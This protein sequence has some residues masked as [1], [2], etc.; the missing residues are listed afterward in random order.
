M[1]SLEYHNCTLSIRV[2]ALYTTF[3]TILL[4]QKVY[5]EKYIILKSIASSLHS[6]SKVNEKYILKKKIVHNRQKNYLDC[7][8]QVHANGISIRCNSNRG[9]WVAT[10]LENN[11]QFLQK[12]IHNLIYCYFSE[13]TFD[14][15]HAYNLPSDGDNL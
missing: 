11:G 6:N 2:K 10:N 8:F 9:C 13:K 1:I 5:S 7:F 15:C 4:N 14:F 3:V 12:H